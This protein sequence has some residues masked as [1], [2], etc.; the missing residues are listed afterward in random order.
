MKRIPLKPRPHWE[1]KCDEVGFHFYNYGGLYWNE[2][3]CYQFTSQQIDELEAATEELHQLCLEA[4]DRIIAEKRHT[5]LSIPLE[6]FQICQQSWER[7]D[8]SLYGRF[9]FVYD[10]I[11]PP[12]LLEYNADTPTA[13]LEASIVQWTWLE[14]VF[15]DA[16]QFNSIHEKLLEQFRQIYSGLCPNQRYLHLTCERDTI[17]D[18]GTVEY[19][20]DVAIQAG[21]ETKHLYI[22]EIGWNFTEQVF[23]DLENH[24]IQALF[25][26]YPWEWMI[27][28][29][30]GKQLL[31]E[32][33]LLLEPAWK[34][35]LSNKAILP[36][37]WEFFPDHPNLLPAYFDS[38]QLSHPYLSK[39]IFSREGGNITV[40]YG[41]RL[42]Q[43]EGI[44]KDEP[45][46]YQSYRPLPQFDSYYPIIGSWIV[47]ERAAGI[48]IREDRTPIT[49]D[50]SQFIPHYFV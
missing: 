38:T 21:F 49:Q 41:D 43:T 24:P 33:M 13:L 8:P 47:G 18:L 44:Y 28:D 27:A 10:G 29:D 31:N 11:D 25:K 6:F 40:Y 35:I 15:P 4:V 12:K 30:F 23:C 3:V 46:I 17:E 39:P 22:D 32:P 50:T 2:S 26:L 14:E 16:D 20:R 7:D 1:Q 36:I 37:L 5:Q 42:Y 9:D 45:L 34:M 19:L 48:G